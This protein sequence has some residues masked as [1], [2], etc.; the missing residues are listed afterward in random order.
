[1]PSNYDPLARTYA[2][3]WDGT[4]KQ[5]WT[6]NGAWCVYDIL[7]ARRFGLG[8]D[9]DEDRLSATKWELY[10]IAQFND[11]LVSDGQGGREPRYRFT[12]VIGSAADARRVLAGM[13]SNF[14]AN[15]YYGGGSIFPFQ[16]SPE[17]PAALVGAANVE[18]GEFR[19]GEA[20]E[21]SRRRSA[22][23]VTFS[24]PDDAYKPGIEL[25]V[26]DDLVAKYGF[27]KRDVAAMYCTSR[28]QAHRHGRHLLVE[29]EHE[30]ETLRY[31]AGLDH[32][33][34]RPGDIVRVADPDVVGDR[35]ACRITAVGA[36]S[37]E[38]ETIYRLAE[39]EPAPP[40]GGQAVEDH[41]PAGWTRVEPQ[42]TATESV[43]SAERTKTL[44]SGAFLSASAW[45]NV[46]LEAANV[47]VITRQLE[48]IYRLAVARP[49]APAGGLAVEDHLPAGWVAVEPQPTA[50]R[51]VWSAQR[52]V[53]LSNGEFQRA[54]AWG[55]VQLEA[56]NVP[57][58]TRQLET[59][60]RLAVNKPAA[61]A[62][63]QAVEDHLPAGW[64]D[65]E[66]QPTATRSAWSAR[67]TV[68]RSNGE[69]QAAT[70]WGNVQL[71]AANVPV[72]TRQLE[73]I[74][75]R[76]LVK[77]AAPAGGQAVEDHL[78]AGWATVE[79]GPTATESVWS[80]Q[81]TVTRSNGEFQAATAW[82][83]VQLE[84][85]NAPV[86]TREIE[87]IYRLAADEPAAPAGG[88]AVENHVPAE[89]VTVEPQPT[90]TESVWSAQRTAT[91]SNGA[92]ESAT[93]WGDVAQAAPPIEVTTDTETIYRL[94]V[95]APAAPAGGQA[96]EDH[97][98]AEW[99]AVEPRP[100]ATESVWSAERT[101]TYHDAVFVAATAW[102]SVQLEAANAPVITRQL[103]T[104]YR[105][106]AD[107][108]A[109]PAGGQAVEDHLPDEW[110]TVEP[111][112]TITESVWS[113]QRTVTL[114]N[115][116]FQG[117]TVWGD[118]AQAAPAIEVTT[119]T[120]TIYRLAADEPA[121]PAG[122]QA[123]EDH[124]PDEWTR[125][126]LQ[127][128][129]TEAV[130]S[131]ER[132]RTYHDAVF[133]AATAWGS[134]TEAAAASPGTRE[135]VFA[136]DAIESGLGPWE[137]AVRLDRSMIAGGV[138]AYL[139]HLSQSGGN[140]R[141]RLAA[142]A[143]GEPS[144]AGPEFTE[145]LETADVAFRFAASGGTSITLKGPNHPDNRFS[146]A[147]EP[148]FWIPDN[149]AAFSAWLLAHHDEVITLTIGTV[150]EQLE[151]IYRLAA[152]EPAA[153]AGGQ[154]VEDHLPDEWLA[155]EPQ[156]T[157]TESVW[158]AQ[159]TA[160]LINGAFRGATAW[161]SL[162][163]EAAN[164]PVITRELET[165]YRLA[166]NEPA[167]P[168]GGQ[169]VDEH[170]PAGWV[171]V[172]PR[173]TAT[174]SAWSAQRTVT[175]SNGA[176]QGATAWGNVQLEAASG[177]TIDTIAADGVI[178][179]ALITI[180]QDANWY[181]RH[182]GQNFGEVE[183][184]LSVA[185]DI[186]L[187]RVQF[188][189]N[190][191]KLRFNRTGGGSL[192]AWRSAGGAGEGKAV[193]IA[194][195]DNGLIE[196]DIAQQLSRGSVGVVVLTVPAASSALAQAASVGDLVNLVIADTGTGSRS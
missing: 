149:A 8:G 116:E 43:W 29:Q 58:I 3:L 65:V 140:V 107:E 137:G 71:E 101:R 51:S 6:D 15:Q 128:T 76:A 195:G 44:I 110:V 162:Q 133:V 152:D 166:V 24:D 42:P 22:V 189:D 53:T 88:Q 121:A 155:V 41:L 30:S 28:S 85:A 185:D 158:S 91:Y 97:V 112:P 59:I 148:Y 2:G 188:I 131:A 23:A 32:A 63:G 142:T 163:L 161:G 46:Q 83:N 100:T 103:E 26:D 156:P 104:I 25:V 118:V 176:F 93:V 157:A 145:A 13:L 35:T 168:A 186:T 105:L 37:T 120:D 38:T 150:A 50:T 184:D 125:A 52:T 16:D 36:A 67:R 77:P 89:W 31:A 164:V 95:D 1:M 174:E 94:A 90:I 17:D 92:F 181:S 115:G 19:Y 172:E 109:A 127:P 179:R 99:V 135:I 70:A 117:A 114:S 12:G 5:A 138:E 18:E 177:I 82:G 21:Q 49:A 7:R 11:Q 129:A 80:A 33:S 192:T 56:A 122:G 60:Y 20:I 147:S 78:P 62:G 34:I 126:E 196:L 98:P 106:A 73:T 143:D 124:L 87:T 75:R 180:G 102:G 45:G 139:R 194:V 171:T 134:V 175:R 86:I 40:A 146:D 173:P 54:T 108:P 55:N 132:T 47:P 48:T 4:F 160:T 169:D 14:R 113:A 153:P 10:S 182:G 57:V 66:P 9:I 170:H 151:T 69:F 27:K 190:F 74:Y 144:D 191:T 159:R 96:V 187:T 81:R 72:I 64:I 183:G 165:I 141:M 178:A 193:Y 39:N 154:A 130:W 68:T 79:P 61:P 167:A 136:S 84:A 123:V 119:D 111:Q